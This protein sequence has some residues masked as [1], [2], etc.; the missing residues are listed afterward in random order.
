MKNTTPRTARRA[1]LRRL[2]DGVLSAPDLPALT[3]LL[4]KDLP[5]TLGAASATLLLWD[6]KLESFQGVDLTEDGRLRTF[7]PE[8]SGP[9][10]APARW[11]VS[12]GQL[13]QTTEN[14]GVGVLVPLLA[15]SGLAG[16]L[17]LGDA[18]RRRAPV[19]PTEAPVVSLIASRAALAIENNTYQK[20]LIASERLAALGTMAGM[21][22]HDFRGPMTVIR[23]YAETLQAPGLPDDE[24]AARAGLI[25]EAVDRLERMTTETLDFTRGA[26]R[27]VL[28]PVPVTLL[29]LDLAAGIEEELPGLEVVQ[30]VSLPRGLRMD[31][32]VDKLRRAV[33]NVAAN[34]RDAMNGRGRL[35]LR[36]RV[37]RGGGENPADV[38]VLFLADE[39]PGVAPEI[40]ERLF[41]PF[42]TGGKRGGTGLGL[43]VARRFVE[44]HGGSLELHD[45]AAPEVSGAHF[46][47][48]LPLRTPGSG[49]GAR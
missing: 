12:D 42:V 35:H 32:D 3:R 1:A 40:R 6:R 30:D 41:Q 13:L 2:A 16:T 33:S 18:R 7:R 5:A 14:T 15:R 43:A 23:G 39:G 20:E 29:L 45:D 28:R 9:E 34:A 4:T 36:A 31:L 44:D 27:L 47:L 49:G 19:S 24:I 21:L 25:I 10:R 46:R 48:V 38:L 22:V 11:L 17:I 26:E 8:V 37:E